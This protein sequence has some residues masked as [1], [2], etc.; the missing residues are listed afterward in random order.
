M[1]AQTSNPTSGRLVDFLA[2]KDS[3]PDDPMVT[4]TADATNAYYQV[5]ETEEF[6]VEPPVE[7]KIWRESKSL[8][9]DD[10]VWK[11]KK[12]LPGRRAA[13]ARWCDYTRDRLQEAGIVQYPAQQHFYAKPGTRIFM[14]SH[15][16]DFHGCGRRSEVQQ[17]LPELKAKFKLKASD[18]VV[19]GA[20]SHLKRV[21]WRLPDATII[22]ANSKHEKNVI[23]ALGLEGANGAATPHLAEDRPTD[24]TPLDTTR[25]KTFR[26]CVM[27]LLYLCTDRMYIQYEIHELT[28]ELKVPTE[29]DYRRLVRVARYLIS[30]PERGT[31]FRRPEGKTGHVKLSV[32]TDTDWAGDKRTRKSRACALI[33]ADGCLLAS[34][35]R[36]QSF[37]ALSSAEAEFGGLHTGV[38]ET[39]PF[40]MLLEWLG[41]VVSWE[42]HTDSSAARSMCHRGGVGKVRHMDLRLLWTQAAVKRLGLNVHKVEGTRNGADL[43]TKKHTGEDIARLSVLCD[44]VCLEDFQKPKDV[45]VGRITFEPMTSLESALKTLVQVIM[46]EVA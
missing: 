28:S 25:S 31:I 46:F 15:M 22:A 2:L 21:R 24:S 34:I 33:R 43:G 6:Y 30:H 27:G 36:K 19:E 16:D 40:K 10:V 20:Y 32:T 7:W 17:I 4:F 8:S 13:A 5:P 26:Q 41:F 9:S 18:V 42:A 1:F 29:Y 39:Y 23:K 35:V 44:M 37:L 11:L 3:D 45:E 12:Q 14:E 38:I